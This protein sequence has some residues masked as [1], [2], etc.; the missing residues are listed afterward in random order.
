MGQT[1]SG[2]CPVN[3]EGTYSA[4]TAVCTGFGGPADRSRTWTTSKTPEGDGT[5]C[6]HVSG[7]TITEVCPIHCIGTWSEWDNDCSHFENFEKR[8]TFT[9]QTDASNGG[10]ACP[11]SPQIEKC[12]GPPFEQL[13]HFFQYGAMVAGT[14]LAILIVSIAR[15][16]APPIGESWPD[17]GKIQ[18]FVF[19]DKKTPGI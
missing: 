8:R 16:P 1:E 5:A 14:F 4:W 13:G 18:P 7:T 19:H 12:P 15:H 3:C 9:I 6:P 11:A 10:T 17:P 2:P